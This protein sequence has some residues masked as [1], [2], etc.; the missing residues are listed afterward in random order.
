MNYQK[1]YDNLIY[2]SQNRQLPNDVYTEI[3]H[4]I[5]RCIGGSDDKNNLVTL[6]LREHFLAHLLLCKINPTHL[7]LYRAVFLMSKTRALKSSRD[8]E[9]LKSKWKRLVKFN[10]QLKHIKLKMKM[11]GTTHQNDYAAWWNETNWILHPAISPVF[12]VRPVATNTKLVDETNIKSLIKDHALT[13]YTPLKEFK[14]VVGTSNRKAKKVKKL[15][16]ASKHKVLDTIAEDFIAMGL[17]YYET[18]N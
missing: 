4:I 14:K 1:I 13:T 9:I 8:F 6:T 15:I 16:T 11:P 2:R 18:I 3:H 17:K 5:P 7:G 10:S 12:D